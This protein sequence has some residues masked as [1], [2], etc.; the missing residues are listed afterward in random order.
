MS[1]SG[2][3]TIE[4]ATCKA[5]EYLVHFAD[6][7]NT[8][9]KVSNEKT[10]WLGELENRIK[11]C[12]EQMETAPQGEH[13]ICVLNY[14]KQMWERDQPDCIDLFALPLGILC[15][16]DKKSDDLEPKYPVDKMVQRNESPQQEIW[17]GLL[18]DED[19]LVILSYSTE[20]QDHVEGEA[21]SVIGQFRYALS[22]KEDE[23]LK[24]G[25][26]ENEF[27]F[28]KPYKKRVE[29]AKIVWIYNTR[30]TLVAKYLR[31][32]PSSRNLIFCYIGP[33]E[34]SALKPGRK[35]GGLIRPIAL[36]DSLDL[37]I[38]SRI[39]KLFYVSPHHDDPDGREVFLVHGLPGFV[40]NLLKDT[41][42]VAA[43]VWFRWSLDE[44]AV[45]EMTELF[46]DTLLVGPPYSTTSQALLKVKKMAYN[47]WKSDPERYYAWAAPVLITQRRPSDREPPQPVPPE[48][49]IRDRIE[50]ELDTQQVVLG[51]HE[52][53]EQ[54]PH[55]SEASQR[56]RRCLDDL[57][58]H[59]PKSTQT[60]GNVLREFQEAKEEFDRLK[61]TIEGES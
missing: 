11:S 42:Q 31:D 13:I 25:P 52:G 26:K 37:L 28:A 12:E 17:A 38:G 43:L 47:V 36:K 30:T 8:H 16:R 51:S 20:A 10:W 55:L 39:V 48:Q 41:P 6:F 32:L 50:E 19:I 29:N 45:A 24:I 1:S 60:L 4:V 59:G 2:V 21:E 49:E 3:E 27:L 40:H 61:E 23:V 22:I 34:R 46:Y 44:E 9:P 14:D 33:V 57:D 54:W 7:L 15:C 35:Y 5:L 56:T 58:K 18:K 53:H